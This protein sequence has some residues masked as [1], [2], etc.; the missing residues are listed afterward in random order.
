MGDLRRSLVLAGCA[1]ATACGHTT[2]RE[3]VDFERMRIQQRYDL[4]GP[5]NVFANRQTMQIPPTGTVAREASGDT[6]VVATGTIAGL[7]VRGIPIAITGRQ[8]SAGGEKFRIYCA[9]CHGAAG[10]GSAT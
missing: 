5:S 3:R 6:G 10:F 4:F 8:L 1:L 2:E 9:V 7:A